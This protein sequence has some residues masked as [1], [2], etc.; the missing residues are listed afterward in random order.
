MPDIC[1]RVF[2]TPTSTRFGAGIPV[3]PEKVA[4]LLQ[5]PRCKVFT[6][7]RLAKLLEQILED[8]ILITQLL[9][10]YPKCRFD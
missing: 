5:A 3:S 1:P 8:P 9:T 6:K 4:S 10:K 2:W 7:S